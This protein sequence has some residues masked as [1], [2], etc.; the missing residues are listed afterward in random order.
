MMTHAIISR[1]CFSCRLQSRACCLVLTVS[2]QSSYM[3]MIILQRSCKDSSVF[4]T[5]RSNNMVFLILLYFSVKFPYFSFLS[6]FKEILLYK[7]KDSLFD[8]NLSITEY[9]DILKR[10]VVN[11]LNKALI[12]GVISDYSKLLLINIKITAT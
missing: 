3:N 9:I 4:C 2:T 12:S 6:S 1:L 11:Q 7:T 10:S 8:C 5:P